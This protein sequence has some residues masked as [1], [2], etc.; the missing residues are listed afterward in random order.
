MEVIRIVI[1]SELIDDGI[2]SLSRIQDLWSR[3]SGQMCYFQVAAI[4]HESQDIMRA[5]LRKK[6]LKFIFQYKKALCHEVSDEGQRS[7]RYIHTEKAFSDLCELRCSEASVMA[8]R[9]KLSKSI[10]MGIDYCNS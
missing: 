8:A 6:I 5:G 2:K 7:Y 4:T 1:A 3:V 10:M 9:L